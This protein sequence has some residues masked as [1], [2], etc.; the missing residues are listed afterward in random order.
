MCQEETHP[1]QQT[2]LLFDHLSSRGLR[3][4]ARRIDRH[5]REYIPSGPAVHQAPQTCFDTA[6][7]DERGAGPGCIFERSSRP[8]F[9]W[10]RDR[11]ASQGFAG[12]SARAFLAAWATP[13]ACAKMM[14]PTDF[15]CQ[16]R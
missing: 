14:V 6:A 8:V 10:P 16:G 5:G 1:L 3:G 2:V 4:R 15:C 9:E 13:T 7:T 12:T 11:R